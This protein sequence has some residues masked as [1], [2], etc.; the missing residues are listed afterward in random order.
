MADRF[1]WDTKTRL[2]DSTRENRNT[3]GCGKDLN[4]FSDRFQIHGSCDES[5]REVTAGQCDLHPCA[6]YIVT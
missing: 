6:D 4:M 1:Q 3:G 2:L 5:N